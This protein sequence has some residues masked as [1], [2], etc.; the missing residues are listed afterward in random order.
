MQN[1]RREF[2]T[3][4]TVAL[5]GALCG[6]RGSV[7]AETISPSRPRDKVIGCYTSAREILDDPKYIDALQNKLG[8]NTLLCGE[9]IRMPQWLREMNPLHGANSMFA[10]HAEDDSPL[11]KA[12]AETHRRGMRFWLYFSG[13][14]NAP[15]EREVMAKTFEG[16]KFADLPPIPHAL[17]QGELTTCFEKPR[18]KSYVR[19]LFGYAPR[20]YPVDGMYVSHTRYA[21]PSFWTNLFGCACPSCREAAGV[22]GY[23][24]ERMSAAMRSLR[25][26]RRYTPPPLSPKAEPS[27]PGARLPGPD[28]FRGFSRRSGRGQRGRGLAVFSRPGGGQRPSPYA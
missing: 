27:R 18:V 11:V 24:F 1:T 14:H 12:I 3:G 16:V 26:K 19:E 13:H 17:S 28:D 4:G 10:Q 7:A 20:T 5:A 2:L 22:M 6:A 21:T 9:S 15:E 8:V 25:T 23:D